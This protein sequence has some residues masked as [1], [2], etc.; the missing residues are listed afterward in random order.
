[1]KIDDLVRRQHELQSEAADLRADLALDDVLARHG[2]VTGV[3]SAALGLMVWRDL[4]PTVVC[5]TLD[6]GDVAQTGAL[7]ALHGQMREVCF[8]NDTG[9]WNSDPRY[10]DGL[11]LGL[12]CRNRA[13]QRWKI[14]IW[15]VDEPDRQPDLAHLRDLPTR[16]TD[17][18]RAAILLVKDAWAGRPEYGKGVSRWDIYAAVLDDGVRSPA[19]FEEWTRRRRTA[20]TSE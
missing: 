6:T 4:D 14:D 15:F 17:E 10:P 11:Y 8:R 13:G 12:R 1:M 5:P 2:R 3:G 7:L 20:P 19:D 9:D 16:L 18:T